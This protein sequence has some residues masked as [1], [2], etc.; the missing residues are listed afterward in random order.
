MPVKFLTRDGHRSKQRIF[1]HSSVTRMYCNSQIMYKFSIW[2]G[3]KSWP[4]CLPLS[5]P[6][7]AGAVP[8]LLPN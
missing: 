3:L 2:L 8:K 5:V 4:A 1:N 7:A 6:V